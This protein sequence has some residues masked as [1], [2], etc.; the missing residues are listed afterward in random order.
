[1]KRNTYDH[2]GNLKDDEYYNSKHRKNIDF[3]NLLVI[4]GKVC[5]VIFI[6]SIVAY[7]LS[8]LIEFLNR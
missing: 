4:A 2:E 6:G 5:G 3:R 7:Y 1:M 8:G